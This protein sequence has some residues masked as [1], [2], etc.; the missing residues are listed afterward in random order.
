MLWIIST[1]FYNILDIGTIS[2]DNKDYNPNHYEYLMTLSCLGVVSRREFYQNNGIL[3]RLAIL[4]SLTSKH[5]NF[6]A[7]EILE[8][9]SHQGPGIRNT[10]SIEKKTKA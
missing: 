4:F 7:Q 3:I 8:A 6:N 9:I 2:G 5:H 1:T 10:G